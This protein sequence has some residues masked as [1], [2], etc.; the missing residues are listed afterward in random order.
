MKHIAHKLDSRWGMTLVIC[1]TIVVTSA[2]TAT[3]ARL[4]DGRT[5]KKATIAGTKLKKNTLTGTQIKES[6][7]SKVPS[8]T[9][10][11]S[12]A[13]ASL[14]A[15]A[16][17]LG[18]LAPGD[19]ARGQA[20]TYSGQKSAGI[21][22]TDNPLLEIPGFGLLKFDCDS[23]GTGYPKF[24]NTSADTFS[25]GGSTVSGSS[26]ATAESF[27]NATAGGTVNFVLRDNGGT[28]IQ[29]WKGGATPKIATVTFTSALCSYVAMATT[30]G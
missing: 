23:F 5:I 17:A 8:A 14:A 28:T 1:L 16:S 15:N 25:I 21:N 7:L 24:T 12:S 18:G 29:I 27:P 6:A 26:T 4:I 9:I 11:D 22:T 2:A 30:N 20:H 3:A 19:F 10:A 13:N